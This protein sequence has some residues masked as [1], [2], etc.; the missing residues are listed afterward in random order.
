MPQPKFTM[1]NPL[2]LL[3][4][5]DIDILLFY[6]G[7]INAVFYCVLTSISTLFLEIYDF[8]NETTVGL[9][10]LPIGG[11]MAIGSIFFGQLMN[12]DYM[13]LQREHEKNGEEF[14][15]EK[16]LHYALHYLNFKIT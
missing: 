16:V 14:P 5:L 2:P 12:W 7:V 11:G 13:R 6:N 9:C 3:L 4:N 1:R 8:L 10:F 15:V